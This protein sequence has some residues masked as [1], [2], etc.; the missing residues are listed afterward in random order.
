MKSILVQIVQ[1]FQHLRRLP[2]YYRRGSLLMLCC[3]ILVFAQASKMA[4]QQAGA[5][6]NN[7]DE[8]PSP[9]V[10]AQ[11]AGATKWMFTYEGKSANEIAT[12]H[13][14][15]PM[16]KKYFPN[17]LVKFWSTR[18]ETKYVP[19]VAL[20]FLT[21]E[22]DKVRVDD[23]RYVIASGCLARFCEDRG[24]LWVDTHIDTSTSQPTFVFAAIDVR[25]S[26]AHLWLFSNHDFYDNPFTIPQDLRVNVTR[27]LGIR[28]PKAVKRIDQATLVDPTGGQQMDVA[29]AILGVPLSLI[30]LNHP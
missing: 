27:W 26:S 12:D 1:Q 14:F 4:A 7:Q 15:E 3:L 11:T 13:Q 16:L 8:T 18:S 25:D 20:E 17:T 6:Q 5:N 2:F 29:P 30:N 24:L 21:G 9:T 10:E 23:A 19:G 28:K 22:S